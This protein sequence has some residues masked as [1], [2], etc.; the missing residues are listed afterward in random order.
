MRIEDQI[1]ECESNLKQIKR[2]DPDPYYVNYFFYM[3]IK[4]VN[5]VYN[6]I[7]EEA[8]ND[9]GLSIRKYNKETF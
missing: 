9:F 3:F 5:N 8:N 2:F 1:K 6:G 7:F 4:S